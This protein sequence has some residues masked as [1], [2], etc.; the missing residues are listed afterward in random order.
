MAKKKEKVF[1]NVTQ[2]QA[3]VASEQFA[4]AF[5]KL[6]SIESKMNDEL[7]KVRSKYTADINLHTEAMQ[8]PF[9]M[10]KAYA[11][12]NRKNWDGK[13]LK[14]LH[15][16]IGFRAGTNKVDKKKGFTW[17]SVLELL[18][19]FKNLKQFIRTK[20]EVNK[21]EILKLKEGDKLLKELKDKA[22]IEIAQDETFYVNTKAEQVAATA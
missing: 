8:E 20:E 9:D 15:C 18:K 11:A 1:S 3:Q 5:N 16:T 12:E 7:T 4:T 2:E 6:E 10:L 19:K 13:S 21:E 22:F 17:E 14:L